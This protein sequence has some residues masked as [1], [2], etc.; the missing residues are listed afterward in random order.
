[1]MKK[2]VKLSSQIVGAHM[3]P[4]HY[5]VN[6]RQISNYAASIFDE[7]DRYFNT[8][9]ESEI[10]AHPLFA[11]RISW[12][13]VTKFFKLWQVKLPADIF[14]H[15]LHH[16]EYLIVHRPLKP[17]DELTIRGEIS[18]LIPHKLGA[19]IVLKFDYFDSSD[20]HVLT[21]YVTAILFGVKCLDDGKITH[22]LPEI[23]RIQSTVPLWQEPLS[24]SR[25]APYVYDG[26]NNIVYP[27]HTDIHYARSV[28]LPDIVLQGTATLAMGV[29]AI[30]RKELGNDPGRVKVVAGKFTGIVVPP[31]QL[32]VR[33]LK[34]GA[35]D[36]SFDILDQNDKFVL[37]GGYVSIHEIIK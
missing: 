4:Y 24:V 17:G 35:T 30:I 22:D 6:F 21:E 16:S 33:L 29:S 34:K 36:F 14:D 8:Q 13:I 10:I 15:L 23:G 9:K 18:G 19:K 28:G 37:R 32:N 31:N 12:E 25:S 1:M 5:R 7:N 2:R 27:I 11:V 3:K 26:C 20:Q